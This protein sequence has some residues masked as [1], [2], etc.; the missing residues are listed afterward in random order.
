M[1]CG[2]ERSGMASSLARRMETSAATMAK[3]T[4][5][6]TRPRL[7]AQSSMILSTM[8]SLLAPGAQPALRVDEEVAGGD[9]SLALGDAVEE[10][11]ALAVARADLHG[12]RLEVA[13]LLGDEDVARVAGVDQRLRRH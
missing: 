10:L 8:T 6:S 4:P 3:P 11:H 9:H 2:S 13:A 7:R 5:S 1:T 12:A